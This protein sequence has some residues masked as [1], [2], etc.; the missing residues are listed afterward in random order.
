MNKPASETRTVVAADGS[1]ITLRSHS[2]LTWHT[3][4]PWTIGGVA[5]L[6]GEAAIEVSSKALAVLVSTPAGEV[7]LLP[8]SYALR[9]ERGGWELNVTVV[10]GHAILSGGSLLA[11]LPLGAGEYGRVVERR[12]LQ[13]SMTG[14]KYPQ[15]AAQQ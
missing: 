2:R 13:Q 6:V 4:E 10:R 8:G 1:R 14:F 7:L 15:P 11:L 5:T 12:D 9:S 3:R